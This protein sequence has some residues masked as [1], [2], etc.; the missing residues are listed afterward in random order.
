ML[1][2]I[3][4]H[5]IVYLS[6]FLLHVFGC[7]LCVSGFLFLSSHFAA[8][9]VNEYVTRYSP[10]V[11][12]FFL[13]LF[14]ASFFYGWTKN[15]FDVWYVT[16]RH[17]IAVDQKDMFERNEAF[18]E[19]SR[20]QD[21]LFEKSGILQTFFGFGTLKVQ[22]AGTEADFIIKDVSD[23]ENAAHR[24]MSLRDKAKQEKV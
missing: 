24:I 7:I 4:K 6:D 12:G 15:Y 20:I 13:L 9:F 22:S 3:H 16:D 8:S 11:L 21:V 17:I 23:V 5:F 10:F 19:L 18:M 14:W 1:E 2:K